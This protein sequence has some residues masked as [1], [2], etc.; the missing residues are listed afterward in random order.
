MDG[1]CR[2]GEVVDLVHLHV[3]RKGDVVAH[4]FE[5]RVVQQV[6]DV[7]P[8]AGVEVVHAQHVITVGQQPLAQ[9]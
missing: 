7:A 6:H 4:E 1:R 2:A 5:V 8:R 9:V 3:E